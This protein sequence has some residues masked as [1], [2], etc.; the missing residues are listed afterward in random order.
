M[1]RTNNKYGL[2]ALRPAHHA[3]II[4]PV[5]VPWRYGVIAVLINAARMFVIALCITVI[6][7]I[8]T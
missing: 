4:E 1:Q 2:T 8:N 7:M 5:P 6:V 3:K